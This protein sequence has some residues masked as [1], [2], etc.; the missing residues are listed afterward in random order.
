MTFQELLRS[1]SARKF[2]DFLKKEDS[3]SKNEKDIFYGR[4]TYLKELE[5]VNVIAP[6]EILVFKHEGFFDVPEVV[7]EGIRYKKTMTT[8]PKDYEELE[9]HV[10]RYT[11]SFDKW[12][13]VLSYP[14]NE[15]SLETVDHALLIYSI[16]DEIMEFGITEEDVEIRRQ[17]IEIALDEAEKDIAEG[18]YYEW[19]DTRSEAEK[20]A[21]HIKMSAKVEKIMKL[22]YE[23]LKD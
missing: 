15:R 4:Y 11:F 13:E 6:L 19:E 16:I 3:L 14:I 5:A 17:E 12:A 22:Y 21:A 18:R 7:V 20:E 23:Y 9:E 2:V 1:V 8:V 10:E